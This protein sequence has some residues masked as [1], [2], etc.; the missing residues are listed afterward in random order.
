MGRHLWRGS[1]SL[2]PYHRTFE[3]FDERNGLSNK[4]VCGILE[5]NAGNI[6]LTT[7]GGISCLNIEDYSFINYT[8]ANG[9]PLQ[10]INM[11]ACLK[12]TD[13]TFVVGGS[14]GF[15]SFRPQHLKKNPHIPKIVITDF[16]IWNNSFPQ[17]DTP[18]HQIET[19]NKIYLKYDQSQFSVSYAALN[20]IF[21]IP[22]NMLINWKD[23]TKA[24][25]TST[26][27]LL[28]ITQT[29]LPENISSG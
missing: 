14:N 26:T 20:Y 6:W 1:L 9:L 23:L 28:Q 3:V 16:K 12:T 15:I 19:D 22:T 8:H 17:Y 7:Q 5:D 21:P 18:I 4:A 11:H 13:G 10:E 24:G 29:S 27:S 2:Q 25:T